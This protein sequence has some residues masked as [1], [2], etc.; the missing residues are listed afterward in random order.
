MKRKQIKNCRVFLA[1]IMRT[2]IL[3]VCS[4][5]W[6]TGKVSQHSDFPTGHSQMAYHLTC[7]CVYYA[8]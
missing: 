1:V 3:Y 8:P 5:Q 7:Y 2:L 4:Q 6:I